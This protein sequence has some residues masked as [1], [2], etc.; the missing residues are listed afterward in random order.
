MTLHVDGGGTHNVLIREVQ[1]HPVNRSFVHVDF[2]AVNMAEQQHVSVQVTAVGKPLALTT[3]LMMLQ[4]MDSV[5][6]SALPA[7][8]P[9]NIEVDVTELDLERPILVSDL[10][11]VPGVEY[12]SD[13]SEHVFTL[14]ATARRG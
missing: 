4:P 1:R 6:L 9:A 11:A 7:D 12:L 2:Y 5:M 8:I 14:I 3:G 13:P 10:P